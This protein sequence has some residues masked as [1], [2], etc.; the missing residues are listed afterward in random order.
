MLRVRFQGTGYLT[1]GS[2]N[3]RTLRVTPQEP[4]VEDASAPQGRGDEAD[5]WSVADM[6]DRGFSLGEKKVETDGGLEPTRKRGEEA[7][8]V[9]NTWTGRTE[10]EGTK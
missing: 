7:E 5:S 9:V 6:M 8:R 1:T 2:H 10:E 4:A 3:F